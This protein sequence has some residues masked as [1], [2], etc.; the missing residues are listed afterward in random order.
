MLSIVAV[1]VM[2]IEDVRRAYTI[3]VGRDVIE[4]GCIVSVS[5]GA[6]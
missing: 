1:A 3:D 6:P 5:P 4:T 2:G